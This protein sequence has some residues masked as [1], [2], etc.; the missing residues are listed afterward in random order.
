MSNEKNYIME[1][2]RFFVWI[3]WPTASEII[4]FFSNGQIYFFV[5]RGGR[6]EN[7]RSAVNLPQFF[8]F[9]FFACS[10]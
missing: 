8:Y 1:I 3:D 6:M 9:S 5:M 4:F 7:D 10:E 2:Q